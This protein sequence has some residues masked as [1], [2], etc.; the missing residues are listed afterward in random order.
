MIRCRVECMLPRNPLPPLPVKREALLPEEL[1][2]FDMRSWMLVHTNLVI[3]LKQ[4]EHHAVA[5]CSL[6]YANDRINH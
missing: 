2:C 5:V 3:S 4:E 6:D 1:V